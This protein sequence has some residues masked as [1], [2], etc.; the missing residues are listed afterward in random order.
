MHITLPL[1]WEFHLLGDSH[2]PVNDNIFDLTESP[3]KKSSRLVQG[4]KDTRFWSSPFQF[5]LHNMDWLAFSCAN[6]LISQEYFKKEISIAFHRQTKTIIYQDVSLLILWLY[7]W[8]QLINWEIDPLPYNLPKRKNLS[9][10]NDIYSPPFHVKKPRPYFGH[11][12]A[13]NNINNFIL[14]HFNITFGYLT[15]RHTSRSI[16]IRLNGMFR[17]GQ[18]I[19]WHLNITLCGSTSQ[20]NRNGHLQKLDL[21]WPLL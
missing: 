4:I 17:Y 19:F 8:Y 6:S 13:V 18:L 20:V 12:C 5:P 14:I 21:S 9:F 2:Y 16:E 10:K 7:E 3:S 11:H 1:Y 15:L